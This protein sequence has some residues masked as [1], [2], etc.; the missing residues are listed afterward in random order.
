MLQF[1]LCVDC[2]VC[3]FGGKGRSN[4]RG[5]LQPFL[6]VICLGAM[7]SRSVPLLGPEGN[8]RCDDLFVGFLRVP[9]C[10]R[11]GG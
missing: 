6:R 5:P 4:N 3:F 1:T 10:S 8:F 7:K 11:G 9:G 2:G